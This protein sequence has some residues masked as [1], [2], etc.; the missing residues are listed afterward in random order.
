MLSIR[1][2]AS[3]SRQLR[4]EAITG[5]AVVISFTRLVRSSL[6]LQFWDVGT[7]DVTIRVFLSLAIILAL[8]L[9]PL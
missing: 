2:I 6:H 1:E 4:F 5:T 3:G 8:H 7:I 9:A